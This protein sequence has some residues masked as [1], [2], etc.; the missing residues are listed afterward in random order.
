MQKKMSLRAYVEE[1]ILFLQE[2]E[3]ILQVPLWI[4]SL[5]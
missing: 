3:K 2:K 5:Q 4:L 1:G